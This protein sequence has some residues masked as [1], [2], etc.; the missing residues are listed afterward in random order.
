MLCFSGNAFKPKETVWPVKQLKERRKEQ[1]DV[2]DLVAKNV[3]DGLT[4][5]EEDMPMVS[6][7]K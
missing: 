6:R 3:T 4:H 7:L 2:N 1:N 5:T